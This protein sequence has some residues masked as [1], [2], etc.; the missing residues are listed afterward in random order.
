MKVCK[1]CTS[2]YLLKW[3]LSVVAFPLPTGEQGSTKATGEQRLAWGSGP[4]SRRRSVQ[5]W[6]QAGVLRGIWR[7]GWGFSSVRGLEKLG[8]RTGTRP[9]PGDCGARWG[10]SVTAEQSTPQGLE[11]AF[12][13][14]EVFKPTS[15][16]EYFSKSSFVW[17]LEY[18]KKGLPNDH[19]V[20]P[21]S[22]SY[23]TSLHLFS[24]PLSVNFLGMNLLSLLSAVW[25]HT[26]LF[27][28]NSFFLHVSKGPLYPNIWEKGVSQGQGPAL[29]MQPQVEVSQ[30]ACLCLLPSFPNLE[31]KWTTACRLVS[32]Y[33]EVLA[34]NVICRRWAPRN[35]AP[36]CF[37]WNKLCP[38]QPWDSSCKDSSSPCELPQWAGEVEGR[39]WVQ[40]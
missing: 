19:W 29:Q 22:P 20:Y 34:M 18:G 21:S 33:N 13:R 9:F 8:H 2:Y 23:Q 12:E 30:A 38:Q 1:S 25:L 27:V 11:W 14:S 16:W 31:R 5:G 28:S 32:G 24:F 37:C 17:D 4:Q 3:C 6:Q 35:H 26:F 40:S 7:E 10:Q 39:I 15:V 36:H